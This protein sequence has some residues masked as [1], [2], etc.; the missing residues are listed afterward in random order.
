MLNCKFFLRE[1]YQVAIDLLKVSG[2]NQRVL[3]NLLLAINGGN[4]CEMFRH[5][6][7]SQ[8]VLAARLLVEKKRLGQNV[9]CVI[10]ELLLTPHLK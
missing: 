4:I 7:Q 10:F 6:V 5:Y 2:S 8:F 9:D 3:F 1:Q